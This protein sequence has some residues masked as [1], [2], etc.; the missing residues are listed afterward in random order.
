MEIVSTF[1]NRNSWP[2]PAQFE[3][4]L[5]TGG[6]KS[7][8]DA[9]DSVS[10]QS[11][12]NVWTSFRFDK[13]ASTNQVS[14]AIHY[15][16]N[17]LSALN[18]VEFVLKML[19]G[20]TDKNYYKNAVI[21]AGL[22]TATI[23]EIK[24]L[25]NGLFLAS[26]NNKLSARIGDS[27][28]IKD[29]TNASQGWFFVPNS[30]RDKSSICIGMYLYNET[31]NHASQIIDVVGSM[32]RV[33]ATNWSNDDNLALVSS[34]PLSFTTGTINTNTSVQLIGAPDSLIGSWLYIPISVYTD[35][36]RG[37]YRRIVKQ[38]NETVTVSPPISSIPSNTRVIV[39]FV[40]R[41]NFYPLVYSGSKI[42]SMELVC[43]SLRL[44]H[45]VV[46]NLKL[47]CG[48]TVLDYP[49]IRIG[50]ETIGH[51]ISS[52]NVIYSNS[53]YSLR[54]LF[55]V[56]PNTDSR[57]TRHWVKFVGDDISQRLK[58][59]ANDHFR[60]SVWLPN[61]KILK[62]ITQDTLSPFQPLP[63]LQISVYFDIA[64][65]TQM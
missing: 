55:R 16:G 20:Q 31:K 40:T 12:I 38:E 3:L 59:R 32:V 5:G 17:E 65:I 49:F 18:K 54:T 50:L 24:S 41:D 28:S 15:D 9:F 23:I 33:S 1:R 42:S 4:I 7:P 51:S 14:G 35:G 13:T 29:P 62:F 63:E 47:E 10:N 27:F 37:E 53:P 48:K 21:T 34:I 25:G 60:F 19:N 64:R 44:A 39:W 8:A 52:S 26:L 2:N 11:Y 22:E 57:A 61:G 6:S 46:P 45:I 43:Y 30:N 36:N 58:W 56:C